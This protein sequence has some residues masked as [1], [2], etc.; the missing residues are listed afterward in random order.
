[1]GVQVPSL[2]PHLPTPSDSKKCNAFC[3]V[4]VAW[5]QP[6]NKPAMSAHLPILMSMF[7]GKISLDV[8]DI[9][10]LLHVSKKHIYNLSSAKK[11]P[12]RLMDSS[13]KIL[14]SIVEMAKYLDTQLTTAQE[15]KKD[16]LEGAVVVPKKRGRPRGGGVAKITLAFQ[17]ALSIAIIK[18]E[19]RSAFGAFFDDIDELQSQHASQEGKQADYD[20]VRDLA[21][22]IRVKLERSF[23]DVGLNVKTISGWRRKI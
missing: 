22:Q 10:S 11:L 23:M 21:N 6:K 14:V 15:P 16:P 8:D 20:E 12:F 5:Q 4:Q 19:A 17:S 7:P 1:M 2:A 9:A 18:Q 3:G 13:D